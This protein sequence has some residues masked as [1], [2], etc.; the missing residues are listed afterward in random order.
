M[1][2]KATLTKMPAGSRRALAGGVPVVPR[3]LIE[4]TATHLE[5]GTVQ[6]QGAPLAGRPPMVPPTAPAPMM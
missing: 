1:V 5:P 6:A 4:L 3:L 2:V